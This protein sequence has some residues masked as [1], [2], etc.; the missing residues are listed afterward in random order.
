MLDEQVI[1]TIMIVALAVFAL[2]YI[3][4]GVHRGWVKALMT[5]GN[6]TL[7]AFLACF[8]S[9]D[10]TTI[11]RDYVY[12]L[13]LWVMSLFG[14]SLEETLAEFEEIIELLPLFA[15]VIMTPF[16]FLVIFG[17]FHAI[18][19]F[20][21]LFVY[22]PKKKTVDEEGETVKIKRFIPWWSRTIG[23]VIG[24][25]NGALLLFVILVPVVGYVNLVNN[26]AD[27]Y[28]EEVDTAALQRGDDDL[29]AV[30]YYAKQD[31]VEPI[32]K[33]W[34][35]KASYGTLG[36]PMFN[37]M[38]TTAYH[39]GQFGLETEAT[40]AIRLVR[41]SIEFV[42]SDFSQMNQDGV[43]NLHGI[44]ETLGESTLM[45][46]LMASMISNMC[47]NWANGKALLGMERPSLGELLDPTFDVL[48]DIL[49]T[50]DRETLIA[51]LDTL[52]DILDL[53]VKSEIFENL[54]DSNKVMDILSK[55][56][57]LISNLMGTFEANEHLA[58]MSA[59][60]KRL[61]VRAVT[62]SLDME[63]AELTGKLTESINAFKDQPEQLSQE[64]SGIVQDYLDDQNIEATVSPEM[65][66]EVAEAISKEFA[67]QENVSEEEVIDF[68]LNYASENFAD[69]DGNVD[70]DGDGIPDGSIDDVVSGDVDIP[71][72]DN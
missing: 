31:Y 41:D 24:V 69:G 53:L 18:I 58:P 37:Y 17:I 6:I 29:N 28:F 54:G 64:L 47:D 63:N 35:V 45:P 25:V 32:T 14:I 19:G 23:G 42:S 65:T 49:V 27:V 38:T 5:T 61:C 71:D 8:L 57:D 15:G 21:L 43:D 16:I 7:S 72:Y 1:S 36:R 20:I 34:F 50:V 12:P 9:R 46:E 52:V 26:V 39:D 55:N 10:L 13:F 56:P 60:I 51:D 59:E 4:R 66:D 67:D 70:L 11:A 40:T 48:L 62:Q 44:V 22:K 30:I 3:L 2:I 68:V 33:N